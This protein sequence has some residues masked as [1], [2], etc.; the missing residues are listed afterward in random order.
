MKSKQE[1]APFATLS[2]LSWAISNIYSNDDRNRLEA[3]QII[4]DLGFATYPELCEH[5]DNDRANEIMRET[6]ERRAR[7]DSMVTPH[8]W[9]E[10]E[11]QTMKETE[12][13]KRIAYLFTDDEISRNSHGVFSTLAE[14]IEAG[15]SD[16]AQKIRD[17]AK[18]EKMTHALFD[19][20]VDTWFDRLYDFATDYEDSLAKSSYLD[21]DLYYYI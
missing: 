20:I 8:T 6:I 16:P 19:Y 13:K 17:V 2:N 1:I 14:A 15:M 21:P 18:V 12:I 4:V 3:R 5:N 7:L 9:T 11:E 10:R